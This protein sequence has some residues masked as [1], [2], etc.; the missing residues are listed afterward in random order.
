MVN[1]RYISLA[2]EQ[3]FSYSIGDLQFSFC[4][5]ILRLFVKSIFCC[6]VKII[7]HTFAPKIHFGGEVTS[8]PVQLLPPWNVASPIFRLFDPQILPNTYPPPQFW[9]NSYLKKYTFLC[10]NINVLCWK[11]TFTRDIYILSHCSCSSVC[12]MR[13]KFNQEL[14]GNLLS[15]TFL[16]SSQL[17]L[18]K[19]GLQV[20]RQSQLFP[21]C[22]H[23]IYRDPNPDIFWIYLPCCKLKRQ[24]SFLCSCRTFCFTQSPFTVAASFLPYFL[25][26]CIDPVTS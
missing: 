9:N 23:T 19:A 26:M 7:F 8:K 24:P 5:P 25:P 3:Y 22:F 20:L 14:G 15:K 6:W 18:E 12:W 17:P 11:Y 16:L 10:Q 21:N 13:C 2:V 1:E 4:Q